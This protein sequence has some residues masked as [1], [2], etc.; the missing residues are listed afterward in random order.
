M[1]RWL[2]RRGLLDARPAEDRSNETPDVSPLEACLQ[3]SLF[4]CTPTK[5]K[6]EKK[7]KGA[8]PAAPEPPA[9]P[10]PARTCLGS[11]IGA[12]IDWASLRK[13]T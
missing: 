9:S 6:R 7:K 5:R 11:G 10:K 8:T 2:R 12:R 3:G 4:G 1:I 13:R